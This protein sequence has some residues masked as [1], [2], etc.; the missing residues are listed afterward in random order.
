MR[1]LRR[2]DRPT[3][4]RSPRKR[5]TGPE[6]TQTADEAGCV[7]LVGTLDP[8]PEA[9]LR[10]LGETV[11]TLAGADDSPDEVEAAFAGMSLT[12]RT[13]Y[14]WDPGSTWM[15]GRSSENIV[16]GD[17]QTLVERQVI[18]VDPDG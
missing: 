4:Q 6:L 9:F 11:S 8:D 2:L 3:R 1:R 12:V 15:V 18:V 14:S 10:V 7:T 16:S 5:P 17:D 13:E